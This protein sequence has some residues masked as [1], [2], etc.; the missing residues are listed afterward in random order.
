MRS[1]SQGGGGPGGA[2]GGGGGG[3]GGGKAIRFHQTGGPEVLKLESV[4]C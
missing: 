1:E 3:G 4:E 2:G